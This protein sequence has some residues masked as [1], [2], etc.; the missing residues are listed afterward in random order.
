MDNTRL[1]SA[2]CGKAIMEV[3]T[4]STEGIDEF[5]GFTLK[6]LI[7]HLQELY[8]DLPEEDRDTVTIREFMEII[9]DLKEDP[10]IEEEP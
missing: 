2:V 8:N 3:N 7:E 1:Y 9:L 6:D 10:E 5:M 4:G